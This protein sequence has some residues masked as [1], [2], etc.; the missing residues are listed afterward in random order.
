MGSEMCIRDRFRPAPGQPSGLVNAEL[1]VFSGDTVRRDADGFLYFVGRRDEMIKTSGYRVSPTEVEEALYASRL[2]AEAAVFGVAHAE[3]GQS[4]VAV[5]VPP[6]DR[7]LDVDSLTA[8]C[9][10]TLPAF[11]VPTRFD[12]RDALPRNPNGKI[13]RSAL[14]DEL[15]AEPA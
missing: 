6:A 11:M 10:A 8:H 4:I 7:T 15:H 3:L 2:V 1:A 9:R 13:N 5:V 14:R 12:I